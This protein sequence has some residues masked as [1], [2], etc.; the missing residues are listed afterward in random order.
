[1]G[2]SVNGP[3]GI[4]TAS[5]IDQ[6]VELEYTTKV[7][8]VEEQKKAYQL[9]IDAYSK[10]KALLSDLGSAASS[11]SELSSFDLFTTTSTNEE[12]ATI[13]GGTGSVDAT[14]DVQVFQL[15][16]N[17]KMV[18]ADGIISDQNASLDSLGIGVGTI[19]ID[20]VEIDID[21]DDTIQD[22]RQ[23]INSATDEDGNRIGVSAS[24]L[25]ITEDN[26][27][28]VLTSKESGSTG[29]A[30]RDISGTTLE[31]LGIILDAAG[32]KGTTSQELTSDSDI[33]TAWAGLAEGE[34]VQISGTDRDGNAINAS[35]IKRPGMTEEEFLKEVSEV[36]HGMA[37]VSFDGTGSLVIAD[38]IGGS[39]Q[40][41]IEELTVGAA[42][43]T[44]SIT[45]FGNEGAGVL[46]VGRDSYFSVENI[47]MSSD[48]NSAT[49]FVSGVTFDFHKVSVDEKVT[50]ELERD[51][52]A[53]KKKFQQMIDAY[54]ALVRFSKSSTKVADP[55]DEDAT[56]GNLAGD[57]TV[58]NIVSRFNSMFHQQF[59][60]LNTVYTSFAM[61]GLETDTQSGE[62]KIDGEMFDEAIADNF[63]E[64]V[65]LFI[66][67]GTS[68]NNDIVMGRST[69][70]TQAGVYIL[71]EIDADHFR[72]RLESD[73]A[74]YTSEARLGEIIS[75][76]EGPLTGLSLTAPAG[77]IGAGSATFTLSK[78]ISAIIDE[79]VD[80]LTKAQEG[81]VALRT[82]S[83]QRSISQSEDRIER[84]KDRIENYRLRLVN[85]FSAMEQAL[86]QMQSQS[87]NMLSALG[88]LTYGNYD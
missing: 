81:L 77:S 3:S 80:N 60:D 70:D 15:A 38:K 41:S 22:L 37:D 19:S 56:S 17:E 44:V 43:E 26:Y 1:M 87:A 73:T 55:N 74:W 28:L 53:I 2:I 45:T 62:L 31:D 49:G 5:L 72:A 35:V 30:Y 51:N 47:F 75:F 84:L 66:S 25:K 59:D 82:E 23:K 7:T 78:G 63:D 86:S 10:L 58:R 69:S 8:V 40:L 64:I 21:T 24:V 67:I 34:A 88:S 42:V 16:S 14:Y 50:V 65:N 68:D 39:S 85:Q 33:Q 4:D 20:G 27:R 54:N 6:L 48:S 79:E 83:Y 76:D 18:S 13:T 52:E 46:S 29:I 12:I 57:M 9:K 61:V 71:E 11:L 32:D 36:F